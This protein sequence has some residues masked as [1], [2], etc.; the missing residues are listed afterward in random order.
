M[1]SAPMKVCGGWPVIGPDGKPQKG[2]DGKVKRQGGRTF[3]FGVMVA[4]DAIHVEVAIARVLGE[5][6]FR[7][8]VATKAT[9]REAAVVVGK[10]PGGAELAAK[11]P[12]TFASMVRG[13][14]SDAESAAAA[15]A[16]MLLTSKMDAAELVETMRTVFKAVWCEGADVD[17][18]ATFGPDDK[19]RPRTKEV[20]EVFIEALKVNF[21]DFFL[22]LPLDSGPAEGEPPAA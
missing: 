21:G 2:P 7:A 3:S 1:A 9:R 5:P 6:L 10:A 12:K 18:D 19:G 17:L 4:T 13:L 15:E 8:F 11:E 16:I 14:A 20:W 22:G